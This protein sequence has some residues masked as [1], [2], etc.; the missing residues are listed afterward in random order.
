[1]DKPPVFVYGTLKPG[2][3]M[4]RHISHTI[5]DVIPATIRGRLY[6]T[7]FGYPLLLSP[8]NE[9]EPIISGVLLVAQEDL[10]EE[11]V[12][13]I[14][15]IEGEAGFEKEVLEVTLEEGASVEAIVYFYRE[16]PPYAQPFSGTEWP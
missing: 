13:I 4:F 16:E 7:P 9:N 12:R 1:M 3:K 15:V 10:H 14:D 11:M 2:E 6:D 5:R 8:G